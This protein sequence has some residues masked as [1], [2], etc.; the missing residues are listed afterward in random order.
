M[1]PRM[2]YFV[3]SAYSTINHFNRAINYSTKVC[4]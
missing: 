1:S 3:K 4:V 2:T